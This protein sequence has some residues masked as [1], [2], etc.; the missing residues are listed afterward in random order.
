MS[1]WYMIRVWEQYSWQ[2]KQKKSMDKNKKN[3]F[4]HWCFVFMYWCFR[5]SGTAFQ[6]NLVVCGV[7]LYDCLSFSLLL[8]FD[9]RFPH[10]KWMLAMAWKV[11][12]ALE[13][14][15]FFVKVV[16]FIVFYY[17]CNIF[18]TDDVPKD[19]SGKTPLI[20]VMGGVEDT[21]YRKG[22]YLALCSLTL[23]KR[24]KLW[25]YCQET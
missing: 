7:W 3:I 19:T 20:V 14:Y 8:H 2:A 23:R 15:F 21:K 17:L 1:T 4:I 24:R 16:W 9:L 25:N 22:V 12:V 13:L 5:E 11:F 10:I 18:H 6:A